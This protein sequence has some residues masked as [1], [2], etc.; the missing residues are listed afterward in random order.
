MQKL[1][2]VFMVAVMM[3]TYTACSNSNSNS[4]QKQQDA[5]GEASGVTFS[6]KEESVKESSDAEGFGRCSVSG[7]NCKEFEGRGDTC[8][9][10]GHAYKKHY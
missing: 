9:N 4:L 6:A 2:G 8:G 10:C 7:C 1:F 3:T 5:T